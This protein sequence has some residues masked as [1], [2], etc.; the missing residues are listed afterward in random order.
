MYSLHGMKAVMIM[1]DLQ[2]SFHKM[3]YVRSEAED[4][5]CYET[6][7][8]YTETNVIPQD[9]IAYFKSC[10]TYFM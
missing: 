6:S 7:A 8:K 9:T 5:V 2:G 1:K 3:P 4:K 10:Q